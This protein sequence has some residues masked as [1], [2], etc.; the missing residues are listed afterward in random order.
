MLTADGEIIKSTMVHQCGNS[1]RPGHFRLDI[2]RD[3]TPRVHG[4][5]NTRTSLSQIDSSPVLLLCCN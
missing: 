4:L 2:R 5:E 3:E 1:F